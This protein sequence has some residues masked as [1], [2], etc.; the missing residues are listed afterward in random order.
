M[1]L[2][3]TLLSALSLFLVSCGGGNKGK[4][5]SKGADATNAIDSAYM[6][7]K[8]GAHKLGIA[9]DGVLDTLLPFF[10]KLHD[11]IPFE[12]RFDAI[13][14][15]YMKSQ[16]I[17]RKYKLEYHAL[18]K[19][20]FDYFMVSRLEPSMKGDKYSSMCFRISREM[21]QLDTSTYEELFWTWKMRL[22]ELHKKSAFLFK[23]QVE[24][25]DVSAYYPAKSEEEYIMFPDGNAYFNK[26]SKT[27]ETKQVPIP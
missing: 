9:G 23:K 12:R 6:A 4:N 7:D 20:G 18:G 24:D 19:D 5:E 25:G 14:R 13:Y 11:S 15:H 10:V 22:P 3:W 27:W 2:I 1:K 8:Y 21:S 17:E 16:K 26:V